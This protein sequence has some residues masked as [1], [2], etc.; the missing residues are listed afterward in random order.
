MEADYTNYVAAVRE[1]VKSSDLSNF[2]SHPAYKDVL[3]HVDYNQGVQYY[4]L[5]HLTTQ[6]PPSIVMLFCAMNDKFGTPTLYDFGDFKASPTSLRYIYH[7][8]LILTHIKSLNKTTYDIVEIGG[9]YGGLSM[10]I[11]YLSSFYGIQISSYTI[12]DLQEIMQLQSLYLKNINLSFPV[13][14]VDALTFGKDIPLSSAFLISNYCFSEISSNYQKK[15]LEHLFPKIE[16][17]FIAWNYIPLYEFRKFL[18]VEEERP[19]TGEFNQFVY[20]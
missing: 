5:I 12:I 4:H 1:M 10:A 3:E 8:H 20:F 18:R 13:N 6:I 16:H 14:H 17:G 11:D 19:K 9:G 2:K 7:A 15:Y